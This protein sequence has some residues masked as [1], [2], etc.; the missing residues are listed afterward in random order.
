MDNALDGIEAA[1]RSNGPRVEGARRHRIE[2]LELTRAASVPR[3]AQ[4]GVIASIQPVHA[5]P[6]VQGNWR[7][8]LG[9]EED[10]HRRCTRAYAYSDFLQ[11]GVK[12]ALGTDAPTTAYSALENLYVAQTRKAPRD[13]RLPPTEPQW[14]LP[15]LEAVQ[16]AT[17]GGAY[18]CR[19]EDKVGRLE[20]GMYADFAIL[21]VD[22]VAQGGGESLVTARVEET[23]IAGKRAW[24][25]DAS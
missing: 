11:Q 13:A 1:V 24:K 3:L 22:V 20:A 15:L 25:R 7:A 12:L 23:W 5:C 4:L 9:G 16:G 18:A 10:P 19:A 2:H 8:Q 6:S 21:D 14:A 17:R